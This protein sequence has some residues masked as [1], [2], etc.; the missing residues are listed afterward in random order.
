[1]G[2]KENSGA[3]SGS[4]GHISFLFF[5]FFFLSFCAGL[6]LRFHLSVRMKGSGGELRHLSG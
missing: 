1:M 2:K 5:S 4:C 3:G 6:S